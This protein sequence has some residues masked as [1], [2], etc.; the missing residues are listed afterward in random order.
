[1]QPP[2]LEADAADA[3]EQASTVDGTNTAN[4]AAVVSCRRGPR[5]NP[6]PQSNMIRN[7]R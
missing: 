5:A 2:P 1:V 7:H 6:R 4:H 3:A